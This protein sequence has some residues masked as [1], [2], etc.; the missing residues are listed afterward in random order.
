MGT[1]ISKYDQGNASNSS[2]AIM[3]G[4][5]KLWSSGNGT[6]LFT[7]NLVS[8]TNW[9]HC[10]VLFNYQSGNVQ[11]YYNGSLIG[12]GSLNYNNSPSNVIISIGRMFAGTAGSVFSNHF[13]GKIDD[14]RI[15]NRALTQAESTYLATH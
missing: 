4:D 12:S 15:Y 9:Q 10:V 1:I 5:S 13:Y 2:F 11:L 7:T 8:S 6:N 14:I 3:Y